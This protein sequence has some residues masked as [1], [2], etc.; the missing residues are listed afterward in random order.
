M[1][2]THREIVDYWTNHQD[3]CGLSV[4]W[5]EAEKLCW[6][7]AHKRLLQRCHIIPRALGGEESPS[8]LVLLCGQCH[9]EAPNVADANFMWVW[10]RAHAVPFYG[11]YWQERGF[12]E[13]EFIYGEKPFSR[14]AQTDELLQ[15]V[16]GIVDELFSKTSTHWGQGKINPATWAWVL[17]Q[18]DQRAR[19]NA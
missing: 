13:Y 7:C 4:D 5:A 10:L 1:N 15:K 3:E 8:N 2:A 18:V 11:T 9:A 16:S 6:R 17:R 14:L 19:N 12:R